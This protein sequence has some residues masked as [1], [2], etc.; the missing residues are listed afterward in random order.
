MVPT[1]DDRANTVVRHTG[2][3]QGPVWAGLICQIVAAQGCAL[4]ST[5]PELFWA[6]EEGRKL[7]HRPAVMLAKL[8]SA[9]GSEEED[10]TV[11]MQ[12][13]VD[14][15]ERWVQQTFR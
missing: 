13:T 11:R 1:R 6:W 2:E 10:V 7:S 5:G 9:G 12:W 3:R 8:G 15:P 4:V 14:M